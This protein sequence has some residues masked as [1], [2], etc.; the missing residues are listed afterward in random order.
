MTEFVVEYID[1]LSI[2]K[3]VGILILACFLLVYRLDK[4]LRKFILSAFIVFPE[5][6]SPTV[7]HID[8]DDTSSSFSNTQHRK[9]RKK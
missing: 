8:M 6:E 9:N 1:S 2:L 4:G 3:G 5:D 7:I